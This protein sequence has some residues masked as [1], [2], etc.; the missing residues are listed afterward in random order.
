V[1]L[2]Q[3]VKQEELHI[4]DQKVHRVNQVCLVSEEFPAL[5]AYLA[6]K[7]IVDYRV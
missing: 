2:D 6:Q 1:A 7:E 5:T 3:R 4:L